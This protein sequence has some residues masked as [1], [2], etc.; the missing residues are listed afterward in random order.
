MKKVFQIICLFL[1]IAFICVG[2][3]AVHADTTRD[4]RHS[5]FSLSGSEFE[6]PYLLPSNE[7]YEKIKY[8]TVSEAIT[9]DGNVYLLSFNQ[10]YS[11]DFNCK[12]ASF[13]H[14]VVAVFDNKVVKA[15]DGKMYHLVAG[16]GATA[17]SEVLENESNYLLYKTILDDPSVLKVVCANQD[18]NSYYVLKTDGNV[19]NYILAKDAGKVSIVSSA[20]VYS[21]SNY[22]G[23]IIDFNYVAKST[24]T[25]IKTDKKI[26]RLLPT[27]REECS[28]YVDVACEYKIKLDEGLTEHY[29]KILGFSGNFLITTYGKEFSATA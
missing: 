9:E 2:C 18:S 8:L 5:G 1:I 15:D 29:N 11:N 24:N 25:F 26:F 19:Y 23:E 14:K 10:K 21:K 13:S 7:E 6:C 22:D 28:K 12:K 16:D 17:F 20:V 3:D 27:N 4:I